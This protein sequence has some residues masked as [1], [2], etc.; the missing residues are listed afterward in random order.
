[1]AFKER[2]LDLIEQGY[3]EEEVFMSSLSEEERA[4]TGTPED[5]SARDLIAHVAA[6]KSRVA[7]EIAAA[8]R[9][10]PPAP[11]EELDHINA[12]IFEENR[13][14]T[15]GMIQ[16]DAGYAKNELAAQTSAL[17]EEEL[18][19]PKWIG[20]REGR[21]IWRRIV[22]DGYSHPLAHLAEYY[23]KHGNPERA[24]ALSDQVAKAL[25]PLDNSPEWQAT[26]TYNRACF[27]AQAGQT[28][29]ALKL[30]GEALRANPDLVEW[31]KEDPDLA[32][33]RDDPRYH[34]L[35][36]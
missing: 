8:R 1:M 15:W 14:K 9:G 34:A 4:R 28:D 11:G 2:L 18:A 25:A 36:Q 10:E 6:W 19:D 13:G 3:A 20:A 23:A 21:P 30:L 32:S 12:G 35:Y 17:T 31:S 5:W 16:E 22:N 29:Q 33:L 7:A 26:L 24:A 27:A